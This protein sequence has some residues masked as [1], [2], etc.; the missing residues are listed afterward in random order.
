[1]EE[2]CE[3]K[4]DAK[5]FP[6]FGGGPVRSMTN[7]AAPMS[8]RYGQWHKDRGQQQRSGPRLIFFV[9]GGVS[10]SEIRTAYEMCQAFKNWDIYI[11]GTH[12][13]TPTQHLNDLEELNKVPN[14]D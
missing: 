14:Q 8:A 5:N 3:D 6:F 9:L 1:M 13:I 2:A 4:L 11:G 10:Y 12:I 7:R